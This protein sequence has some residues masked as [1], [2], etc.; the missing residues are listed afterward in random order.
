MPTSIGQ[1]LYRVHVGSYVICGAS[2]WNFNGLFGMERVP[3]SFLMMSHN[4]LYHI[5]ILFGSTCIRIS[6]NIYQ[7][8][9]ETTLKHTPTRPAVIQPV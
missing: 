3:D 2:S 5:M 9:L 8:K 4:T 7:Y 6:D 1:I